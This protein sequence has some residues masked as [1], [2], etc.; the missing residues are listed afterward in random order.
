LW[1]YD[2]GEAELGNASSWV[3][4]AK[5]PHRLDDPHLVDPSVPIDMRRNWRVWT[6]DFNNLVQVFKD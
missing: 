5:D 2:T 6:D 3:L 4:L 1:I